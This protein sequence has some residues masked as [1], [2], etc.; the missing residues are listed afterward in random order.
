MTD[1]NDLDV[2]DPPGNEVTFAGR[3]ITIKPL[4]VGKLPAFARAIKP[5]AGVFENLDT[6]TPADMLGLIADHGENIVKAISIASGIDE[7]E[8]AETDPV[9]LL[10]VVKPIIK[11]NSDFFLLRLALTGALG[12]KTPS[13]GAGPTQ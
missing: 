6:L 5:L 2:I 8:L 9:T 4:T 12:Q 13:P 7:K 10:S 3:T 1:T 11:A